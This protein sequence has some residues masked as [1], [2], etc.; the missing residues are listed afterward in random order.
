MADDEELYILDMGE[1]VRIK[2]LAERM[3]QLYGSPDVKIKYVGL[4]PCEKL[5]EELLLD[6]ENDRATERG[7]I[8]IAKQEKIERWEI[9]ELMRTLERALEHH[10]DMKEVLRTVVPTYH[11]Q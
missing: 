7:R 1:P 6:K 4:R 5:Y 10:S 9:E 11:T 8:Y 3:V 2:D